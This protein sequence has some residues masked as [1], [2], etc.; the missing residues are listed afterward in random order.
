MARPLR[1]EYEG[2]IY[3]VTV[4]GNDRRDIFRD[5]HD[6]R[7]FL[8]RLADCVEAHQVR[9]YMFCLMTNHVHL[10][11]ETP[12]GN[13]SEFM[14]R[15]QTAYSVYFNRRHRRSGHLFQGRYGARVVGGDEYIL[16]LSRYIHLNPVFTHAARK[17]PLRERIAMLRRYRW[18]SYRSY[19]GR[20]GRLGFVDYAPMPAMTQA[21]AKAKRPG[22][23]RR[24]VEAGIAESDRDLE[25]ILA[26]GPLAIGS[27]RFVRWVRGMHD[28]L[29][30][31]GRRTEDV[32]LR[33]RSRRL[34]AERVIEIVCGQLG[35]GREEVPRRQRD[36]LLRPI[37][38][39][40]LCRYSGLT[41]R[42]AGEFLNL[43]TGAAV[44]IQL[45]T[46]AAA[47][48]S[49]GKLRRQLAAIDQ[50]ICAEIDERQ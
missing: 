43:S 23:Y 29:S 42:Q 40:M 28:K 37:V 31:K 8:D 11:L 17:L 24:F 45:K 9:L 14:H 35:V 47:A 32:T 10:M 48:A 16:R 6:R 2:A 7:R 25:R 18:S 27:E 39:K 20:A 5:D 19:I 4:R 33:R 21:P 41:Q 13:L 38:A 44:S 34:A 15:L 36:S 30:G 46:L 1:V 50:A 3:H 26:T 12:A 22:E 49:K